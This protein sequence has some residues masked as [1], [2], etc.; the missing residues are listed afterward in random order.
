MDKINGKIVHDEIEQ[1]AS[2]G[3]AALI[4]NTLLIIGAVILIIFGG[5]MMDGGKN[6][7]SDKLFVD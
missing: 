7:V 4:I 5:I 2:S 1:K 3:I 6:V